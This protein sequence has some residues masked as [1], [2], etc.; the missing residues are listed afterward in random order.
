MRARAS[1]TPFETSCRAY[2]L[3]YARTD[4]QPARPWGRHLFGCALEGNRMSNCST[5]S[6]HSEGDKQRRDAIRH[7]RGNGVNFGALRWRVPRPL[8]TGAKRAAEWRLRHRPERIDPMSQ[9]GL[10]VYDQRSRWNH[11][12][13]W[14]PGAAAINSRVGGIFIA[15]HNRPEFVSAP[16]AIDM[17]PDD[18]NNVEFLSNAD[19]LAALKTAARL[20]DVGVHHE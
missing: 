19:E 17:S 3:L 10:E 18:I 2:R 7:L 6:G 14:L 4:C 16:D 12:G 13:L 1:L 15:V 11:G 5:V 8:T 20:S 9:R